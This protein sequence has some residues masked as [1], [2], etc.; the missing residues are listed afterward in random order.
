[1]NQNRIRALEIIDSL[2]DM[3]DDLRRI[4][5][6][7]ETDGGFDFAADDLEEAIEMIAEEIGEQGK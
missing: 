4:A 3:V 2:K 1:M 6:E 5:A 7:E